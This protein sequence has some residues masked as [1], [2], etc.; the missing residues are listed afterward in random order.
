[1]RL[2]WC[3]DFHPFF[4]SAV[5]FYFRSS[6][7]YV[8][9]RETGFKTRLFSYGEQITTKAHTGRIF[10]VFQKAYKPSS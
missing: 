5:N 2:T 6:V 7:L 8:C 10:A 1:M 9:S 4:I 3:D